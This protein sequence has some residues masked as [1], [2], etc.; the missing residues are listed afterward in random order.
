MVIKKL[1]LVT[2]MLAATS[3]AFA[4][5]AMDE[6]ALAATTGQDGITISLATSAKVDVI[7]HDKDGFADPLGVTANDRLNSGAIVLR[8]IALGT[9]VDGTTGAVTGDA[10][11]KIDVDAGAPAAGSTTA[12]ATLNIGITLGDTATSTNTVVDLGQLHIANSAREGGVGW[13]IDAGSESASLLDL[14]QLTIG[15]G[16]TMNI[17]LGNEPQGH[18]IVLKAVL[19]GGLTLS[20]VALYYVGGTLTGGSIGV[21]AIGITDNGGLDLTTN[22]GVDAT[23]NGLVVSVTQLG[24]ATTGVNMTMADVKIGDLATAASIGD[25]EI[26]GLNM[27]GDTIT[28]R[29]H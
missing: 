8:G 15:A 20:N 19:N 27:N 10:L 13:G 4:M 25:V 1:A 22:I 2:A 14:G 7:I 16:A 26:I 3:G 29:G 11:V 21:G 28:I 9:G 17:Q 18:L 12:D 24:N 5:E 6:E 23:T